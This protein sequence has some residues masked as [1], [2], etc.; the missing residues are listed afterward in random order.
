[1]KSK[2]KYYTNDE[3]PI[4]F[5]GGDFS[6]MK[7]F[8]YYDQTFAPTQSNIDDNDI[9]ELSSDT[10]SIKIDTWKNIQEY[11]ISHWTTLSGKYNITM[12]GI[13]VHDFIISTYW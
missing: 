10:Y 9:V 6:D 13:T 12:D 5:D 3:I 11:I 2:Q 7:D 1:M 8:V 4:S